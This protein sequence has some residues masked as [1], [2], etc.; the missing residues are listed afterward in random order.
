LSEKEKSSISEMIGE[1]LREVGVLIFVFVP[2]E[3][4]RGTNQDSW[5]LAAWIGATLIIATLL[6]T[7]GIVIERRRPS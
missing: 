1:T 2:L 3:G 4:Y 7:I 6:I 5:Q